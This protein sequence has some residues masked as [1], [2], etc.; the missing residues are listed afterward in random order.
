MEHASALRHETWLQ[1]IKIKPFLYY[2]DRLI[3][4]IYMDDCILASRNSTK[5]E[6][7]KLASKFK[8]IYEGDLDESLGVKMG[9]LGKGSFNISQP[10]QIEQTLLA[11]G[12][13]DQTKP[14][15][16]PSMG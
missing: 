12:L 5:K 8:I 16:I 13:N 10:L 4:I 1:I 15:D 11:M 7:A 6:K 14:K 3:M 9:C 2:R